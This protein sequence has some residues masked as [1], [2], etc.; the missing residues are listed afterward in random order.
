MTICRSDGGGLTGTHRTGT[1]AENAPVF[2][3]P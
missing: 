1:E 2:V 3:S